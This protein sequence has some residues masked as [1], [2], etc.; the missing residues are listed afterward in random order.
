[1]ADEVIWAEGLTKRFGSI[2]ALH[3]IDLRVSAG[4]VLG[5]LGPNGAGKTTTVRILSTILRADSGRATVLGHDVAK[6]A[7]AVRP[8]IG[9]AGL[10]FGFAMS[11]VMALVALT[12]K[13]AEAATAASFPV[14]ALLCFPS[15]VFVATSL[16]PTAVRAY[17]AHQPVSANVSAVRSLLLG[18]PT[19]WHVLVALLWCLG[20]LAV[21]APLAV[22][23]YRRSD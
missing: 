7:A 19:G 3:G 23:R 22:Q 5:L 18:G 9:M 4:S 8:L 14:L 6:D 16:M 11:W 1:M 15:N 21:V 20:M 17:A 2:A 12:S 13:S 10:L